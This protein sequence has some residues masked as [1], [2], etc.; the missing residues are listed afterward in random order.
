MFFVTQRGPDTNFGKHYYREWSMNEWSNIESGRNR[1]YR[2]VI[3]L[4]P[5]STPIQQKYI[6]KIHFG[7]FC[8]FFVSPYKLFLYE[9]KQQM[10][11]EKNLQF[12]KGSWVVYSG[13]TTAK[14]QT[15][16]QSCNCRKQF[17]QLIMSELNWCLL[18]LL[19]HRIYFWV[20]NCY[21]VKQ[22]CHLQLKQNKL[23]SDFWNYVNLWK[24]P[25][26]YRI[27]HGV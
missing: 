11:L 20:L 9:L 7:F 27:S 22:P 2:F 16:E 26:I 12:Q 10:P 23:I 13:H 24:L 6:K 18:G 8:L 1:C 21:K 19:L 3:D 25:Q 5:V 14:L 15:F 4:H 17:V